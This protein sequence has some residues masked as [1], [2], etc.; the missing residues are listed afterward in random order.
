MPYFNVLETTLV[1]NPF[2]KNK[3][4]VNYRDVFCST[5]TALVK[6]L[7]RQSLFKCHLN[8]YKIKKEKALLSVLLMGLRGFSFM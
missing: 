1:P 2:I 7:R 6:E 4:R 3:I 5:Y 8:K